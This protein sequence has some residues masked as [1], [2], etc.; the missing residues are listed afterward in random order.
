MTSFIFH[1]G[2]RATEGSDAANLKALLG[3]LA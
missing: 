2:C 1:G 3:E